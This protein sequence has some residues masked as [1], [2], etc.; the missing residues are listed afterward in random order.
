[1]QENIDRYYKYIEN[2]AKQN[3]SIERYYKYVENLTEQ[4]NNLMGSGLKEFQESISSDI[5]EFQESM[6]SGLKELQEENM[7]LNKN[8][9]EWMQGYEGS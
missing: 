3:E 7:A 8:F 9:K 1:M 4:A 5:K 2:F 6:G